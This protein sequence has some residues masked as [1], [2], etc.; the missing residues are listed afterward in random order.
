MALNYKETKSFLLRCLTG[1]NPGHE[2]GTGFAALGEDID[3]L[4]AKRLLRFAEK[5]TTFKAASGYIYK[6]TATLTVGL[7]A[8]P[9]VD[10]IVG[11]FCCA[12]ETTVEAGGFI[13]DAEEGFIFGDFI[14]GSAAIR[15]LANQHVVLKSDGKNWYIVSGEPKRASKWSGLTVRASE[16]EYEPSATREVEVSIRLF[17]AN[18]GSIELLVGGAEIATFS[19]VSSSENGYVS[20]SFRCSPG[21]KWKVT[22]SANIGSV[23][24]AYRVL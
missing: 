18:T 15:L 22:P 19:N 23:Y 6:T 8:E 16:T 1:K 24:S 9:E 10:A 4:L 5:S 12:G 7:P 2:I 3:A 11:V 13:H 14:T 17:Y 21:E 20:Y